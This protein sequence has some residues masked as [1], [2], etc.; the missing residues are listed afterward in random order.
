MN[1]NLQTAIFEF[2]GNEFH[3]D[4]QK[5]TVDLNFQSD[6]H[7]TPD[8]FS[9]L[10]QHMEDALNFSIPE[11]KFDGIST[12]NDLFEAIIQSEE[13]GVSYDSTD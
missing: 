2:I 9:V 6:L 1:P 10:L 3:L 4:P 13:E 7:L 5:I 12:I 8:Q 11:E